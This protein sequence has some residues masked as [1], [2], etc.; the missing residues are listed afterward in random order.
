MMKQVKMKLPLRMLILVLGM[1]FAATGF[2]QNITVNGHVEDATG[3]PIIG[4]T[5]RV[6]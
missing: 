5:V 1:F 2:A 6:V 4:A 3:E